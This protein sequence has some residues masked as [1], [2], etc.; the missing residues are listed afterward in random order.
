[1]FEMIDHVGYLLGAPILLI[2]ALVLGWLIVGW[3]VVIGIL[4]ILLFFPFQVTLVFFPF[5]VAFLSFSGNV[6]SVM[7][8]KFKLF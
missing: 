5:Q 1:M 4:V 8:F 6:G 3:T 2:V 7:L